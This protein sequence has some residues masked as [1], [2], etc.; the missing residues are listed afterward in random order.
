MYSVID[1]EI[2]DWQLP[3]TFEATGTPVEIISIIASE[4]GAI[5]RAQDD[6]SLLVR[7]AYPIRPVNVKTAQAVYSFSSD[8]IYDESFSEENGGWYNQVIVTS[9]TADKKAPILELEDVVD[10]ERTIGTTSYVR[11][12][13]YEDPSEASSITSQD[14]TDGIIT[15]VKK[16]VEEITEIITFSNGT[17]NSSYP[18]KTLKNIS[19]L[20]RE[21][22]ILTWND[23]STDI[24]LETESY[25]LAEITYDAEY[26]RYK[27]SG[28]SVQELLTV[29]EIESTYFS[30]ILVKTEAI[31]SVGDKEGDE[32]TTSYLTEE[33]ALV[34][35]GE[36]WIDDN[37]YNTKI[38]S[39]NSPF[40]S[41]VKD[42]DVIWLD[43]SKV[44]SG[45]YQVISNGIIIS[46]PKVINNMTVKQWEV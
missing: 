38:I 11:A 43:I 28:H 41:T 39:F 42:G 3:N 30:S 34:K 32:I 10:G 6:G 25:C 31:A 26:H 44:P 40:I 45:N 8:I 19:W 14:A 16:D 46:G 27:A 9:D 1:W 37:K 29:F 2:F 23:Y 33:Y 12:F 5:V 36:N 15:F 24:T 20:G 13:Y 21:N 35:R 22:I 18:L 4:I 7:Y 17:G